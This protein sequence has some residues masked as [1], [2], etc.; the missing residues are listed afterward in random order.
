MRLLSSPPVHLARRERKNNFRGAPLNQNIIDNTATIAARTCSSGMMAGITNPTRPWF[1]LRIAGFEY[2]DRAPRRP[3]ARRS[4]EA[5]DASVRGVQLYS[6]MN[7]VYEDLVVF[8]TAAQLIYEDYEN[9]IHCYNPC[10]GEYFV[11]NDAKGLANVFYRG[12]RLHPDADGGR[13]REEPRGAGPPVARQLL[14]LG[15]KF[16]ICHAIGPNTPAF[17]ASVKASR[18]GK[19]SGRKGAGPAKPSSARVLRAP[20]ECSSVVDCR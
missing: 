3:L 13:V 18:T 9:V 20:G 16:I 12:V 8:G 1:R 6:S 14:E 7:I 5:D 15:Q 10:L 4:P 11:Q 2:P 19:C 17:P